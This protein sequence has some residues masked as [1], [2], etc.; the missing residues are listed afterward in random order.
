MVAPI[1]A[2]IEHTTEALCYLAVA[3][4]GIYKIY[5]SWKPKAP[6]AGMKEH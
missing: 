1:D 3:A 4:W 2:L 5:R 6:K